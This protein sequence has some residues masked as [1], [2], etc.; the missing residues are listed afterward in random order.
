[1]PVLNDFGQAAYDRVRAQAEELARRLNVQKEVIFGFFN[2]TGHFPTSIGEL[3]AWGNK[4]DPKYGFRRRQSDGSWVP[5]M[6]GMRTPGKTDQDVGGF[7][8]HYLN[9]AEDS[10]IQ[11]FQQVDANGNVFGGSWDP[12][13][14][15]QHPEWAGKTGTDTAFSIAP[16]APG[17]GGSGG[18]SGA[19][20]PA[21]YLTGG[22]GGPLDDLIRA[23]LY[24]NEQEFQLKKNADQRAQNAQDFAQQSSRDARYDALRQ[25][26]LNRYDQNRQ[27][28]L[29]RYDQNTQNALNRYENRRTTEEGRLDSR[30]NQA[31]QNQQ[32]QQGRFDTR[33]ANDRSLYSSLA[34]NLLNGAVQLGAR[35]RDYFKYNQMLSGGRD[36]MQQLF[37]DQPVADFSGFTGG[38]PEAGRIS[39]LM[40]AL[41]MRQVPGAGQSGLDAERS[42]LANQGITP[43]GSSDFVGPAA[44]QREQGWMDGRAGP[45]PYV[46]PE[47]YTPP[48]DLPMMPSVTD[49]RTIANGAADRLIQGFPGLL[50]RNG[51]S[52]M[53]ANDPRLLAFYQS[54]TGLSEPAS[55]YVAEKAAD[56]YRVNGQTIPSSILAGWINEARNIDFNTDPQ[57][58]QAGALIRAYQDETN[59]RGGQY[60]GATDPRTL[61]MY[62]GIGGF[63]PADALDASRRTSQLAAQLG[64][65]PTASELLGQL[66][67]A[68]ARAANPNQPY[69][70]VRGLNQ[71]YE[72]LLHQRGV[73]HLPT[74]DPQLLGLYQSHGGLNPQQALG[75]SWGGTNYFKQNQ[76]PIPDPMQYLNIARNRRSA[77]GGQFA[78]AA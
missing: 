46:G 61:A 44:D 14:N 55:R 69:Q 41:G 8:G 10:D 36:I 12:A 72:E 56:Y 76:T 40:G 20:S 34:Q 62:E 50:Q 22:T 30:L 17:G 4:P 24:G 1:M 32:F 15:A 77:M 47:P 65:A 31:L 19:P 58:N 48:P 68:R 3:E 27:F 9:N 33:L 78:Y 28:D 74:E 25:A 63:A 45:A 67:Q 6:Q 11:R 57:R 71:G 60:P 39:D 2:E 23:G 35:P 43:M 70:M 53:S 52:G 18:A 49:Y 42:F 38:A 26:E 29:G 54:Q 21:D 7:A 51:A 37:G 5:L 64:R 16:S 13:V 66:G 73:D 59:A 75:A